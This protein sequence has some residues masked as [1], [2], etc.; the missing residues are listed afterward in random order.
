[1]PLKASPYPTPM[2]AIMQAPTVTTAQEQRGDCLGIG[3][4]AWFSVG[5]LRSLSLAALKRQHYAKDRLRHWP[6]HGNLP[7]PFSRYGLVT[8]HLDL[9]HLVHR[10]DL[11]VE[12]SRQIQ[13]EGAKEQHVGL[14][15]AFRDPFFISRFLRSCGFT[16]RLF[17]QVQSD[18]QAH[19][20]PIVI[21]QRYASVCGHDRLFQV[22][23]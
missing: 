11:L 6:L 19:V 4:R 13:Q 7:W 5:N 2:V 10:V 18:I 21:D 20:P 12:P 3:L 1:M 23:P 15:P 14:S 16:G 9:D 22:F 17:D 8:Q